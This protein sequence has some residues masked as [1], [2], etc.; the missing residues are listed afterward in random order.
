MSF[1]LRMF[2]CISVNP[3]APLEF[4]TWSLRA[5]TPLGAWGEGLN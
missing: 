4:P 5:E 1:N 2:K 3:T